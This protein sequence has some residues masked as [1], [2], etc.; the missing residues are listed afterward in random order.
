MRAHILLCMLA[1]YVEWHPREA[2]RELMFADAEQAAKA[3]HDPVAPAWRSQAA[4]TKIARQHAGRRHAGAQL[5]MV[6]QYLVPSIC[7]L[8]AGVSA[9]RRAQRRSLVRGTMKNDAAGRAP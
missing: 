3:T 1:C 7:L 8:G 4:L 5:A 2:W 6:G 9:W